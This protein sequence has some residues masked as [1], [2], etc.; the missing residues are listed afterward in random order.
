MVI[1]TGVA[2]PAVIVTVASRVEAVLLGSTAMV[3][4]PAVL[5]VTLHHV[6]SELALHEVWL[7][8]TEITVVPPLSTTLIGCAGETVSTDCSFS[9]F[10]YSSGT[11]TPSSLLQEKQR[12]K[13]NITIVMK[14]VV[15]I[16]CCFF[17]SDK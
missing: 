8:V 10:S 14:S 6:S 1:L 9:S 7:V 3:N 2:F 13:S 12:D 17:V 4:W 5:S 15:F 11:S 16:G